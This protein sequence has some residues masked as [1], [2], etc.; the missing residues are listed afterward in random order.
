MPL[1]LEGKSITAQCP[2]ICA[3]WS[4]LCG[5]GVFDVR[6]FPRQLGILDL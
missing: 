2:C 5:G 6:V 3:K 4:A 1:L